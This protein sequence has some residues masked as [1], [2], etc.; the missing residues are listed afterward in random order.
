MNTSIKGKHLKELYHAAYDDKKSQGKLPSIDCDYSLRNSGTDSNPELLEKFYNINL[1][2]YNEE[3]LLQL[4]SYFEKKKNKEFDKNIKAIDKW[5]S[6]INDPDNAEIKNI[7]SLAN[8]FKKRVEKS[9]SKIFF[10]KQDDDT[11]YP[12]LLTSAE[13]T[14]DREERESY[15]SIN[16]AFYRIRLKG[17]RYEEGEENGKAK[18]EKE[19]IH[20]Y[21]YKNDLLKNATDIFNEDSECLNLIDLLAKMNIFPYD[22]EYMQTYKLE[23]ENFLTLSKKV[24]EQYI[25]KGK[26]IIQTGWWFWSSSMFQ[27]ID[28]KVII[29]EIDNSILNKCYTFEKK[30]GKA[31]EPIP[32]HPYMKCFDLINHRYILIS[33]SLLEEYQYNDKL[34]DSLVIDNSIKD[35]I[36]MIVNSNNEYNDFIKGKSK[37]RIIMST[38]EPGL[39]KTLTAEVYAESVHKPLYKIQS[40]QLGDDAKQIERNLKTILSNAYRWNCVL[41]IDEADTY[42]RDR[43]T[44]I[45]QNCIIGVFLRLLEYYEGILFMT[46]N[47]GEEIDDAILSRC[48]IHIQY[49]YPTKEQALQIFEKLCENNKFEVD[50]KEAK[51]IIDSYKQISGRSIGTVVKNLQKLSH[52]KKE[53]PTFELFKSIEKFIYLTHKSER[54]HLK[55]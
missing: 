50:K 21:I 9:K 23:L 49:D 36:G 20:K 40:A 27:D 13:K 1:T 28:T 51:K 42:V 35:I 4:K 14:H 53:K 15:F 2:V 44:D 3:Q 34:I 10:Y 6:L 7:E 17:D 11:F 19:T 43:G 29:E 16:F 26:S 47:K 52:V 45:I 33:A 37:G 48:T 22:E 18:L 24:G 54:P 8:L 32:F 55:D 5:M 39:G 31:E 12:V 41:L 46:S 30:L 38:G 25:A